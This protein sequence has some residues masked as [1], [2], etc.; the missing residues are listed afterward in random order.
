M[1]AI[2]Q[3][4]LHLTVALTIPVLSTSKLKAS[5]NFK[6]APDA[7]AAAAMTEGILAVRMPVQSFLP[8]PI[9]ISVKRETT[10]AVGCAL[11]HVFA[12]HSF[13]YGKWNHIQDTTHQDIKSKQLIPNDIQHIK[14]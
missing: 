9:R 7:A 11:C 2:S 8:V 3:A 6:F 12:L 10:S 13:S 1:P 4:W 5:V 14:T